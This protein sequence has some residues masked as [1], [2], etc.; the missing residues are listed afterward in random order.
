MQM[1]SLEIFAGSTAYQHIQKNGLKPSDITR[2][3]GASGAAKWLTIAGLDMAIFGT[4]LST[5]KH[6]IN[7]FGT[8]IGAFKLAAAACDNPAAKLAHLAKLYAAYDDSDYL[9]T[10]RDIITYSTWDMMAKILTPETPAQILN[11]PHYRFHCGAVRPIGLFASQK[12]RH[13]TLALALAFARSP[14]RRDEL[15][16]ICERVIFTDPRSTQALAHRDIYPTQN[17]PL[18]TENLIPAI[19]SSGSMPLYMHPMQ[20][21]S[22]GKPQTLYDGGMLDYHPVPDIF[23]KPDNGLTL[24]PHFYDRLKLRW[25]D[26]FYP[27]RRVNIQHLDKIILLHPS[28]AFVKSLPDGRIASRQDFRKYKKNPE[29][30]AKKWH[31][32]VNRSHELGE[33]FL[34]LIKSGDI[35]NHVKLIS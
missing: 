19:L 22:F 25:F 31:E 3:M 4:W 17:L 29:R 16:N 21:A 11:N 33:A 34:A 15:Q 13:Q 10:M 7:L 14:I 9:G 30:R 35:A 32:I 8:S 26:K 6:E 28:K 2:I 1:Q 5:A 24:Y 23:W 27:W 12:L 20:H 18:T